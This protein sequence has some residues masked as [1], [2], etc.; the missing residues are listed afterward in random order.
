MSQQSLAFN[1]RRTAAQRFAL[2]GYQH[3]LIKNTRASLSKHRST[4]LQSPTGSGKTV[5]TAH[6]IE[7]AADKGIPSWFVVHRAELLEQTSEALWECGVQH[8]VIAGR[9]TMTSDAIQ[10]ATIQTLAR[11]AHKLP[12]PGLLIIDEAHHSA[13]ASYRKVIEICKGA[14]VV[15]LTATP[16]RTDGRGLDDLFNDIVEGPSVAWL[17]EQ[18]HLSDYRVIAP[19]SAV[20]YSAVSM[21]GGDYSRKELAAVVDQ[22]AITGDAVD[23]YRRFVAPRTCLVYCVHREHARHVEAAYRAAGIDARYCA[24]DTPTAERQAI[25]QGLKVGNPPVVVS[26]DL[27][28]EGLNA[29]G[30]A[31]VQL[32]RKTH[33]LGLH[34]QQIGRALRPEEGKDKA[35][36]LDH[37]GNTWRHGLPDDEREWTLDGTKKKDAVPTGPNLR[38]CESCHTILRV[39]RRVCHEC[40]TSVPIGGARGNPDEKAGHLEEVD[41][42][43]HRRR[44][45]ERIQQERDRKARR[46]EV[47]R[48]QTM[49]ELVDIA[50][51]RG[52]RASWAAK[53]YVLKNNMPA[54]GPEARKAN[55]DAQKLWIELSLREVGV[56]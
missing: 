9:R 43:E 46:M 53:Q 49:E 22:D 20:D 42:E 3:E 36:I 35:I 32:L 41:A 52:Y 30:L 12:P 5:L 47:G 21:R 18:G 48:A 45:Q 33:S 14:Y 16:V 13:A 25:V 24:G 40:G 55:R 23:H 38:R 51:R 4:I 29:P 7:T 56:R 1:G 54:R 11:R 2:R 6:M 27:F 44:R 8:G 26:V 17:I 15:G 19:P 50:R 34:L 10:V 39:G 37:V 28:G 31:A